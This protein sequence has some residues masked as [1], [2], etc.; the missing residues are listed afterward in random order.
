MTDLTRHTVRAASL[1]LIAALAACADGGKKDEASSPEATNTQQQTVAAAT[2]G[3]E[4]RVNLSQCADGTN[5]RVFFQ[6]GATT[7]SVPGP[8][9]RDAIPASLS[10]PLNKEAVKQELQSQAAAGGGCPGKP[11]SANL[12]VLQDD[13]DHPLL[14]GRIGLLSTPPQ[15]VT[16]QF[17]EVTG[18]LQKKPTQNCRQM[19]ADL[20]GCLGRETRGNV[21]TQVMYV[22]TTDQSARM[23]SGGPLAARCVLKENQVQGCNLVDQLPGNIAFD[24]TLK[25]GTYTTAG[26]RA[27]RNAAVAKVNSYRTN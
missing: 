15:G 9:V 5:G 17:A 2:P 3:S 19:G 7:L 16:G 13:L 6:I 25:A 21:Q 27:A 8:T 24:A 4:D 26:L 12:L 20:L 22:I 14:D 11:I 1:T 23:A 18:N 10:P